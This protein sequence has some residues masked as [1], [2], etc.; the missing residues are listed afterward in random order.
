MSSVAIFNASFHLFFQASL[1]DRLSSGQKNI[2]L[3]ATPS[4]LLKRRPA[5]PEQLKRYYARA[6]RNVNKNMSDINREKVI[7]LDEWK[8]GGVT[9]VTRV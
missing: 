6:P 9:L 1:D 2:S 3:C 5:L 7:N 8:G 4:W